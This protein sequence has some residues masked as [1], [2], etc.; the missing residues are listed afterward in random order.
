MYFAHQRL[1]S[2][3]AAN[4]FSHFFLSCHFYYKFVVPPTICVRDSQTAGLLDAAL[5]D[6]LFADDGIHFTDIMQVLKCID[7]GEEFDFP[8]YRS[9]KVRHVPARQ[10]VHRSGTLFVRKIRDRQGWVIMVVI[11][12]GREA[13]RDGFRETVQRILRELSQLA[14]AHREAE[15][16]K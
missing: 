13:S 7:R 1:P 9:G 16:A 15:R 8:K 2:S 4:V 12:N 5:L 6:N 10:F 11:E 3:H 14:T